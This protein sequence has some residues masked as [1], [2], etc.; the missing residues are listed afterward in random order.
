MSEQCTP[1]AHGFF[2]PDLFLGVTFHPQFVHGTICPCG[3]LM[4]VPGVVVG[5]SSDVL[6]IVSTGSPA[7]RA[8]LARIH[9]EPLTDNSAPPWESEVPE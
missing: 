1:D 6:A 7:A 9:H 3:E 2:F 5:G 4:L 8:Y